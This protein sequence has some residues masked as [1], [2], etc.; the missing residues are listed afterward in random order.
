LWF[1]IL[2]RPRIAVSDSPRLTDWLA[3]RIAATIRSKLELP[4]TVKAPNDVYV[5]DRKVSGVLVE[6]RAMPDSPHAAIAG[7][8]INVNQRAEDFPEEIRAR[9]GSVAMCTGMPV[10]R[11]T[12][13]IALLHDFD[14]TY[15]ELFG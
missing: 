11:Q 15:A 2:L 3:N 6:M 8:G 10:D 14:R 4:A 7:I 1:S 13:A 5:G 12:L 9:A